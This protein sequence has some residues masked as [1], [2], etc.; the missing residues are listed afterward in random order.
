MAGMFRAG[1]AGP[2]FEHDA[3]HIA[4][5]HPSLPEDSSIVIELDLQGNDPAEI[6]A[7]SVDLET[8]KPHTARIVLCATSR[9]ALHIFRSHDME[10]SARCVE[11]TNLVLGQMK[12]SSDRA[13]SYAFQFNGRKT[14]VPYDPRCLSEWLSLQPGQSTTIVLQEY[15]WGPDVTWWVESLLVH[16]QVRLS[17]GNDNTYRAVWFDFRDAY[18]LDYD[19][20]K[21]QKDSCLR[22]TRRV[23]APAWQRYFAYRFLHRET[24]V[25]QPNCRASDFCS[26]LLIDILTTDL[27]VLEP[28]LLLD[29][30]ISPVSS[31]HPRIDEVAEWLIDG[32]EAQQS[33]KKKAESLHRLITYLGTSHLLTHIAVDRQYLFREAVRQLEIS[34]SLFAWDINRQEKH[35]EKILLLRDRRLNERQTTNSTALTYCAALFVPF[36][37]ATAFLSMQTRTK[38]LDMLVY[39]FCGI[40]ILFSTFATVVYF[41]SKFITGIKTSRYAEH[42]QGIRPPSTWSNKWI[43]RLHVLLTWSLVLVSFF[44]GM[45]HDLHIGL[46]ILAGA[47]ATSCIPYVWTGLSVAYV[48]IQIFRTAYPYRRFW[49]RA[50]QQL[51]E[52]K[53]KPNG[54]NVSK[55]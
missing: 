50:R 26:Y 36:L 3:Y 54:S 41:G 1:L 31:H 53:G 39:D 30:H 29:G 49:G 24:M 6:L 13:A 18:K 11:Y 37:L 8:Q 23:P 27:M 12:H 7:F 21:M 33:M 43:L 51:Q 40:A 22:E 14:L 25:G 20:L 35:E 34:S 45:L 2:N 48:A 38:D 55:V 15:A 52:W 47:G 4:C 44:V 32:L 5:Q 16:S 28:M 17:R 9:D 10:D 46:Y 42:L 19:K